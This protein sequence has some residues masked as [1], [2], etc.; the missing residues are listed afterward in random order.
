MDLSKYVVIE[1][2]F[3]KICCHWGGYIYIYTSIQMSVKTCN[4]RWFTLNL[5]IYIDYWQTTTTNQVNQWRVDECCDICQP[6]TYWAKV[7]NILLSLSGKFQLI[8][9][10]SH[11]TQKMLCYVPVE[12][13]VY[14][15]LQLFTS[16]DW[17]TACSIAGSQ[18]FWNTGT[19]KGGKVDGDVGHNVYLLNSCKKC[20]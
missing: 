4:H 13:L 10:K 20:L 14:Q 6:Q 2:G 19:T 12:F 16:I 5:T 3:V 15:R 1:D 8:S 7:S 9:W 11:F 18:H 17:F